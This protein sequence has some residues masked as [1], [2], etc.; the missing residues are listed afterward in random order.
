M[1]I[2]KGANGIYKLDL[3]TPGGERIRRSTG[4]K[5]RKAAQE[6]HDQLKA[7]LWRMDKLGEEPD[8]MFDEAAL[9][10]LTLY[11]NSRDY[12]N[13]LRHV[14][15]WRE[16]FKQR[17]IR[18]L[19]AGDVLDAAPTHLIRENHPPKALAPATINRYVATM[20]RILS[21]CEEWGWISKAPKLT[22]QEEP[23]TRVRWEPKHVIVKLIKAMSVSWMQELSLFAVSTG[24]RQSEITT[25][26]WSQVDMAKSHAYVTAP[27][28]K[29]KKARGVPLNADAM[30]VLKQRMGKHP[31]LVFTRS[32]SAIA[33][34]E[35][36]RRVL[37][38][39]C[40]AVGIEDF[41]FHDFRHT[42]ASW[43]IQSGQTSLLALKELGGWKKI[44]MVLKYAHLAPDHLSHHA[45]A[46]T[47][48]SLPEDHKE[49]PP[50]RAVLSA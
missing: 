12:R 32:E 38:R 1:P 42:W 15:W 23:E 14:A 35:V 28:A 34:Q 22:L 19:T 4:T 20:A 45:H 49:K 7:T 26:T 48:W 25:L 33:I 37:A 36:D 43:H 29:S 5:D 2:R 44:E 21:L 47:F 10:F 11:A 6:Y 27:G 16:R 39:A 41:H 30:L 40:K 9:R 31:T 17:T 24:M 50:A 3:R 18:S 46:V 13:K 8:R